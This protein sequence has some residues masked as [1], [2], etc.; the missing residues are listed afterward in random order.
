MGV[1]ISNPFLCIPVHRVQGSCMYPRRQS[2]WSVRGMWGLED[3]KVDITEI[4]DHLDY[5][6]V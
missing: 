5:D 1:S 3:M 4:T 6:D 2:T